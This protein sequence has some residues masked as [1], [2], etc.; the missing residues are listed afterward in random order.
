MKKINFQDQT[1]H[2]QLRLW[3]DNAYFVPMFEHVEQANLGLIKVAPL[4]QQQK[5]F[6][7]QGAD[8]F[9]ITA[10]KGVL[11]YGDVCGESGKLLN[12]MSMA[13]EVGDVYFVEPY[14]MHSLENI[15]ENEAL[16]L[17]NIAPSS[18][19]GTDSFDLN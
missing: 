8:I 17:L 7:K 6:H 16:L 15:S 3:P 14:Q 18:H 1:L 12:E 11:H 10:G 13:I 5:H 9:I 19:G 4:Q 2:K